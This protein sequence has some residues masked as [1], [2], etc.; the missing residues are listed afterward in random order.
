MKKLPWFIFAVI[1]PVAFIFWFGIAV[2][3][4]ILKDIVNYIQLQWAKYTKEPK[5]T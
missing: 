5:S 3:Y 4:A 1:F 2:A